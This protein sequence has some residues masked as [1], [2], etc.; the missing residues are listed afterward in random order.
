M[1]WNRLFT[2]KSACAKGTLFQIKNLIHRTS[3]PN[4]PKENVQ[5]TEDFLEVTLVAYI[6]TAA[7]ME[8]K[9][10]MTLDDV[11]DNIIKKYINIGDNDTKSC[12]LYYEMM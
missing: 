10:G 3:V 9:A 5:A 2:S 8:Y 12:K 1:I 11:C 7:D 4:D 6:L